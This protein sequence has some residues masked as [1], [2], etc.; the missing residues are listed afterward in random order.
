MTVWSGNCLFGRYARCRDDVRS[1]RRDWEGSPLRPRYDSDRRAARDLIDVI[2]P[3]DREGCLLVGHY[4][5]GNYGDELLLELTQL[6][7]HR[8]GVRRVSFLYRSPAR[9]RTL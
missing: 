6:R 3:E 5:G 8:A 1:F 9:Y 2:A 4:G 7:L